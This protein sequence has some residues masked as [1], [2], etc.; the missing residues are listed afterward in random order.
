MDQ[1]TLEGIALLIK[2]IRSAEKRV[3]SCAERERPP[4]LAASFH[5]EMMSPVVLVFGRRQ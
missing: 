4:Q 2:Q 5:F 3:A 1:P